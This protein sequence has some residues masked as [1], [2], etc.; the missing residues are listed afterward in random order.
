MIFKRK[1]QNRPERRGLL[2]RLARDE[3][4]A[5]MAIMT[6]ALFPAIGAIGSAVDM[7]RLYMVRSQMQAC[8]DAAALA[9]ARAFNVDDGSPEDRDNQVEAYFYGNFPEDYMSVTGLTLDP[10]NTPERFR[11]VDDINVTTVSAQALV[12]MAFMQLFGVEPKLVT[13]VAQAEAQPRPLEVMV[14]LDNTGSMRANLPANSDGVVMTRM[15]ALKE[16]ARSFVNILYQGGQERDEVALGFIAY[17]TTVNVGS[18][19][20]S[21]NIPVAP[22]PGF[23]ANFTY[24]NPATGLPATYTAPLWSATNPLGW[25]GC[26][27]ADATVPNLGTDLSVQETGAWDITRTLPGEGGHPAVRPY[28]VPPMYVPDR[29]TAPTNAQMGDPSDAYYSPVLFKFVEPNN[30]LF[31][32]DG[33]DFNSAFGNALANSPAYRQTLYNWYIGLNQGAANNSNDVVVRNDA[34]GS[35]IS[36]QD[37]DGGAEYRI[38]YDR[39]PNK[40]AWSNPASSIVNP[41]GG[42]RDNINLDQT[43]WPSPNWQCPEPAVPVEYGRTRDFYNNH[44]NNENGAIYPGNGTLHHAGLL[45]G[46][47]LL[48]R[49]DVFQRNNP[50]NEEPRRALV[51][52]TD[53]QTSV[54]TGANGFS[55]PDRTYTWHGRFSDAAISTDAGDLAA[56]SERRFAKTCA[57]LR[58]EQNAPEVYIIALATTSAATLNMFQTCAPGRVY[59]TSDPDQLRQAFDD[60][61]SELV[62]LHLVE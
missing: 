44:I 21:E 47:R 38:R 6:A 46:Y 34:T 24:T 59:R 13:A 49:D 11:I 35:Y 31:R 52:M 22:V 57:A 48:V 33:A 62:D 56:Q 29:K 8:G 3:G 55:Y 43:A 16:S 42:S 37:V 18:I 60:I 23:N 51:F 54:A 58:R 2:A 25:K 26:V 32:F 61:A 28:F 14:V 45:W 10:P 4:G 27:M 50:T 30:N 17:D 39:I 9:G 7:G 19:L 1:G 20:R 36:K 15:V 53:G 40:G 41:A 12:P 5:S